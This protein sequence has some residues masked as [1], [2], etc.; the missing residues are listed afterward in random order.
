[1]VTFTG[2]LLVA[3]AVAGP[4]AA[5]TAPEVHMEVDACVGV[6]APALERRVQMELPPGVAVVADG[7]RPFTTRIRI[8]CP[9]GLV[10]LELHDPVT[11]KSMRRDLDPATIPANGRVRLLALAVVEFVNASWVELT[12]DRPTPPAPKPAAPAPPKALVAETRAAVARPAP[13]SSSPRWSAG[14]GLLARGWPG[15]DLVTLGAGVELMHRPLRHLQWSLDLDV[16]GWD[17]DAD[18]GSMALL[19][20][21]GRGLVA[22]VGTVGRVRGWGGIGVRAGMIHVRSRSDEPTVSGTRFVEPWF[23]VAGSGGLAVALT[24]KLDLA[25]RFDAGWTLRAVRVRDL[26][27]SRVFALEGAWLGG[28]V[29]LAGRW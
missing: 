12:L 11:R 24:P 19:V 10:R 3:W 5:V 9:D 27:G 4:P 17:K 14:G 23:G 15:N 21:S 18:A 20:A 6:E 13:R 25:L 8:S 28:T 22:G 1:M 29:G 7:E 26:D 16:A 2:V